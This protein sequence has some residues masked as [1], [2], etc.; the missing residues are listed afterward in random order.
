VTTALAQANSPPLT[1]GQVVPDMTLTKTFR[2]GPVLVH[3]SCHVL[4]GGG[5]SYLDYTIRQDGA[6]PSGLPGDGVYTDI[7]GLAAGGSTIG[8]H[9]Q[10]TI[11]AGS[12][13]IDVTLSSAN[14]GLTAYGL[15]RQLT[16]IEY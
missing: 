12:H 9:W 4:W 6:L 14:T 10:W 13:T 15:R 11:P 7:N 16:V 8:V 2:G 1:T 3:F 5:S